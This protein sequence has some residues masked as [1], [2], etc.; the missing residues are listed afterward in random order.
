M[1]RIII[2]MISIFENMFAD[3]T[4][5]SFSI[6]PLFKKILNASF[7]TDCSDH[8]PLINNL[9]HNMMKI[10]NFATILLSDFL[11]INS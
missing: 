11:S 8:L 6:N 3:S 5:S 1:A 2:K 9:N 10:T 4:N 7:N